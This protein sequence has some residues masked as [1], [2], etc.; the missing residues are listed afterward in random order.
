MGIL[1]GPV[2]IAY[3]AMNQSLYSK[4]IQG[5]SPGDA[6]VGRL[7]EKEDAAHL[8]VSWA[9]LTKRKEDLAKQ[10]AS[11]KNPA[12]LSKAVQLKQ[13]LLAYLRAS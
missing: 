9:T 1:N 3:L 13:T 6:S 5:Y 4:E 8:T 11:R 2:G 12:L 7:G 10:H